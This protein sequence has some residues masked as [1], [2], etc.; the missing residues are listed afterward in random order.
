V[1]YL[2][3]AILIAAAFV[4]ATN[5]L[6]QPANATSE[7]A[8]GKE[9]PPKSEAKT[10]PE[11]TMDQFLDKLMKAESGGNDNARN[12]LSTAIG[13]FQ[14]IESTFLFVMRRHFPKVIEKLNDTE[15]LALR[16]KRSIARNAAK[17]YTQDNATYLAAAGHKPT[18]PHLRLAFLLG[19]GGANRV[20]SAKPQTPVASLLGPRVIR[21]NPWMAR[22]TAQSLLARAAREVSLSPNS[23]AGVAPRVDPV[24]G[25]LIMPKTVARRPAIRVRC[26]LARPSCRKWLSLKRRQLARKAAAK[27]ALIARSKR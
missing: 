18:F 13:S 24:T 3:V 14:F 15:I 4:T 5:L 21:A 8:P 11:M 16:T 22:H 27:K 12:P 19:A 25:K 17:A 23:L 7:N 1:S 10:K 2:A 20:L 9:P 26:N 6:V